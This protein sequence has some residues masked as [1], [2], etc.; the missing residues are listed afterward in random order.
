TMPGIVAGCLLVFIPAIGMFAIQNLMGGG[1]VP[2]IGDVI[3]SQFGKARDWPF[4]AALGMTLLAMFAAAF[5]VASR[6]R[7]LV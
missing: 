1:R 5:W 3:A 4:G 6:R 7:Q 2:M